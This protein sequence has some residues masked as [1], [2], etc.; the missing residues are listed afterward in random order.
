MKLNIAN[1][2]TSQQKKL[3]IDDDSKLR[4]FYEKRLA[5]EVDGE[6]LGEEFKGYVFKIM[7]GQDKQGFPMKQGVLTQNRVDLL[8][9]PGD[10]CFRGFGR[11][12]GERRRKAVRGC[13]VTPELSVLNLCI[14]KQGE[15]PLPGLTDDEKPRQRG[16]KRASKIRKLFNLS[17]DDDVRKYVTVYARKYTDGKGKEHIKAPKVQRL[18]TPLTLQRKRKRLAIKK[19][20]ISKRK[21][22]AAEYHKVL[23]ARLKEERE[24]RSESL[25]KKRADR[26][27]SVASK[28]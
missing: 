4:A 28:E 15:N 12:K 9:K 1:P 8:M 26:Q 22:E 16:P 23:M 24:R 14:V 3:E 7:G 17:K 20:R 21:A 25:A 19:G 27:A 18:V 10:A 11:R 2:S 5:Q 6:H 13:I